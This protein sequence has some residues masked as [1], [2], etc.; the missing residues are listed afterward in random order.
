MNRLVAAYTPWI[1]Q[2]H[3]LRNDV[4]QPWL[5][6]YV[7]HPIMNMPWL[8]LDVDESKKPVR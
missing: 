1:P 7:R 4:S 3:R 2:T 5:V 6:G 8:F